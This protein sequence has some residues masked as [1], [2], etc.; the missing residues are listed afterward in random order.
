MYFNSLI[1]SDVTQPPFQI[2]SWSGAESGWMVREGYCFSTCSYDT[3]SYVPISGFNKRILIQDNAKV[4]IDITVEPNL[5]VSAAEI[6]CTQVGSEVGPP[7]DKNDPEA[8]SSYPSMFYSQP[9]DEIDEE[10]GRVI[11]VAEGK[12]QLKCYVLIGYGKSDTTKNG[13]GSAAVSD[14]WSGAVD[15][16]QILTT[17]LILLA[18]MVSGVPVIFPSPYFDARTNVNANNSRVNP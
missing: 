17:D 12:R 4:Y 7:E 1:T 18:S 5:Q 11:T 9:D 14:E 2:V 15:P 6:K 13:V 3:G 16:V 8:W 10:T